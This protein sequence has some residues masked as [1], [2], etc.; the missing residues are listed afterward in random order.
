MTGSMVRRHNNRGLAAT[1][2]VSPGNGTVDAISLFGTGPPRAPS[3]GVPILHNF[4]TSAFQRPNRGARSLN[5]K[6]AW[7]H[8]LD[9]PRVY[10]G[11]GSERLDSKRSAR[12]DLAR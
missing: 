1:C 9:L 10:Y 12:Q 8:S 5:L 7:C 3:A 11:W 4:L 2:R 6:M